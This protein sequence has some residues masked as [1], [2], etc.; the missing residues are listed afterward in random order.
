MTDGPLS[1]LVVVDLTRVLA[2]PYCTMV[3]ADLGAQIVA[4]LESEGWNVAWL[5]DGAQAL[6]LAPREHALLIVD[7]MLPGAHG[8]DVLKHWRAHSEAPVLVLSVLTLL[9]GYLGG[10]FAARGIHVGLV[11]ADGRININASLLRNFAVGERKQIQFRGE[12]FNLPNHPNFGKMDDNRV[13]FFDTTLRDGEQSPGCSMTQPEKLRMARA[14]ADSDNMPASLATYETERAVEVLKIQNADGGWGEDG[15]SYK[16][17]Y[18]G[19]EPA[20]GRYVALANRMTE[21]LRL[22]ERAILESKDGIF[23]LDALRKSDAERRRAVAPGLV[24]HRRNR[25]H[26]RN[27][28]SRGKPVRWSCPQC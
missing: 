27:S 14:L 26:P 1:G 3:L 6:E 5:R 21:K 16:L 17:A 22:Q 11:R 7:L 4:S 20:L 24:D 15:T 25:R 2:G 18:K 19:Y 23:I 9:L 28:P 13:L 12:F 10:F 8:L